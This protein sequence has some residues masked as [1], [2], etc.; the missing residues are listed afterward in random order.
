MAPGG[1]QPFRME[2]IK[3]QKPA[4]QK[5]S[6]KPQPQSVSY[7]TAAS[8]PHTG[9]QSTDALTSLPGSRNI[10]T[11]TPDPHPRG[12]VRR[13]GNPPPCA[14]SFFPYSFFAGEERIWPP[15]G[16]SKLAWK[17]LRR[18]KPTSKRPRAAPKKRPP[19]GLPQWGSHMKVLLPQNGTAHRPR[20]G[21]GCCE[22]VEN[23]SL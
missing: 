21:R 4:S 19:C 7:S 22:H 15:E 3:T 10:T 9:H 16:A 12:W 17:K 5:K 6:P 13:A 18:K 23:Y 8:G 14:A 20:R 11:R 2:K 1:R